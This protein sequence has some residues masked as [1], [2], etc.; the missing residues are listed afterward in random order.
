MHAV[1]SRSGSSAPA[2][3]ALWLQGERADLATTRILDAVGQAVVEHGVARLRMQ[4]VARLAGCSRST[5]YEYFP[6]RNVL[7]QAYSNRETV[8]INNAVRAAIERV[9]DPVDALIRGMRLTLAAVRDHPE[10]ALWFEPEAFAAAQLVI[11]GDATVRDA[12]L[13]WLGPIL[14]RAAERQL[15]RAGVEPDDA[16]EWV[17]RQVVSMLTLPGWTKRTP[18]QEARYLRQYLVPALFVVP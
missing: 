18:T 10:Q 2:P 8:R 17:V 15:L 5:L 14:E 9:D 7:L 6:N 11:T 3:P 16:A 4:H 1:V 13:T 12:E